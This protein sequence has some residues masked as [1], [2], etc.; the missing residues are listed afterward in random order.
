M[1]AAQ[2]SKNDR[3]AIY[4]LLVLVGP[5][6]AFVLYLQGVPGFASFAA[7]AIVDALL[8]IRFGRPKRHQPT[9]DQ[10]VASRLVVSEP[11]FELSRDLL[12]ELHALR[13]ARQQRD[14]VESDRDAFLLDPGLGPSTYLTRDGR[15]LWDDDG[16]GVEP[17]RASVY[18]AISVGARKTGIDRLTDL[19][20]K[21]PENAADCGDCSGTGRFS[22]HG[23]LVDVDGKAVSIACTKCGSLGWTSRHLDLSLR[24]PWSA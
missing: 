22:A 16:W 10:L 20:P 13:S 8:Y 11:F 3:I 12:R 1:P 24:T 6:V 19:L 7:F 4:A 17:T 21:R 2:V 14:R 9:K 5:T 23:Q 18:M 15:V